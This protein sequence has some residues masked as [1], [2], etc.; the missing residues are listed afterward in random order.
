MV[1]PGCSDK[2]A[3]RVQIGPIDLRQIGCI[4]AASS[5]LGLRMSPLI[6][7]LRRWQQRDD[8]HLVNGLHPRRLIQSRNFAECQ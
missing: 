4:L 5:R 6:R 2:H 8:Q 7:G 1:E 3:A